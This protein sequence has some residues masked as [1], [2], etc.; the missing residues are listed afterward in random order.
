MEVTG[1]I[2]AKVEDFFTKGFSFLMLKMVYFVKIL[3]FMIF[4]DDLTIS[5]ISTGFETATSGSLIME[6]D[7]KRRGPSFDCRLGH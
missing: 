1:S 7:L 3:L 2:P 4:F 6:T 5:T